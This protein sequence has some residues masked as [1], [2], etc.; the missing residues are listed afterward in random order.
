MDR[1]MNAPVDSKMRIATTIREDFGGPQHRIIVFLEV[2]VVVNTLKYNKIHLRKMGPELPEAPFPAAVARVEF[3]QSAWVE[4]VTS[5]EFPLGTCIQ[6]HCQHFRRRQ[7]MHVE[8]SSELAPRTSPLMAQWS[9]NSSTKPNSHR[10][11]HGRPGD[12]GGVCGVAFDHLTYR[13]KPKFGAAIMGAAANNLHSVTSTR[14]Q[15]RCWSDRPP[16]IDPWRGRVRKQRPFNFRPDL[17]RSGYVLLPKVRRMRLLHWRPKRYPTCMALER[18]RR[19]TT[20]IINEKALA[21]YELDATMRRIR[22]RVSS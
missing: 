8:T 13:W 2:L 10:I 21:G 17:S 6:P 22:A 11:C 12:W 9:H 4:F 15:S 20:S 3:S 14:R 7:R 5:L 16:T 19:P 1:L 18:E